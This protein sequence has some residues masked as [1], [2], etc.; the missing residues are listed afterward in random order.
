MTPRGNQPCA[1]VLAAARVQLSRIEA[2]NDPSLTLEPEV[3]ADIERLHEYTITADGAADLDALYVHG[4]LRW[5]RHVAEPQTADGVVGYIAASLDLTYCFVVSMAPLPEPLLPHFASRARW[6]EDE[7]RDRAEKLSE[8]ARS[9]GD[10]ERIAAAIGLWRRMIAPEHPV[11]PED[12]PMSWSNL[13]ILLSARYE[14]DGN[15]ADLNEAIS[16][17]RQALELESPAILNGQGTR[18]TSAPPCTS[19]R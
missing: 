2:A 8:R 10:R 14:L 13:G 18:A 17:F 5:H 1:D 11:H 4:W 7:L 9:A 15:A 12:L 6:A 3:A 19:G 16:A